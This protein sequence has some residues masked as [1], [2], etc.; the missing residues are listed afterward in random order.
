MLQVNPGWISSTPVF[1]RVRNGPD[2]SDEHS[3]CARACI[4]VWRSHE[5]TLRTPENSQRT[6]L[7]SP[8][9][10]ASVLGLY[11]ALNFLTIFVLFP[12]GVLRVF[13]RPTAGLVSPT[14]LANALLVV[15]IVGVTLWR[16][17]LGAE[18]I[19]LRRTGFASAISLTFLVWLAVNG[20]QATSALLAPGSLRLNPDWSSSSACRTL[21]IFLSQLMGNALFEEILFRGVLF[22][23]LRLHLLRRGSQPA[24]AL[25]MA[26]IVSQMIFAVIHVPLRLSSGMALADLPGELAL[27]FVLGVILA[28]LYWRT[29]NLYIVVGI[30]ALSNAS[31]PFVE[32]R[33]DVSTNGAIAAAASLIIILIWPFRFR[34]TR[35]GHPRHPLR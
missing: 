16:G 15:I 35:A 22:Q 4:A 21:G 29:G 5:M 10:L 13:S 24:V 12:S 2:A 26:L 25:I 14:L 8:S 28:L 34:F 9:L 23:Q 11:L 17:R 1:L 19:G 33:I 7:A 3:A 27:L 18:D 20:V 31:V 30:H 6:R 32:P